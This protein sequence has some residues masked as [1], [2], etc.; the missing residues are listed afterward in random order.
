MGADVRRRG[1]ELYFRAGKEAAGRTVS[2]MLADV[3][4]L[5]GEAARKALLD[6][7][8]R[9][10]AVVCRGDEILRGGEAIRAA[11]AF[12]GA[13]AAADAEPSGRA[14]RTGTRP[15]PATP[16]VRLLYE[17]D[18]LLVADKPAG[19]IMYPG[20]PD[21]A[22]TLTQAVQRVL[23]LAGD[24]AIALPVHRLDRDTTGVCLFAKHT[25]ALRVLDGDLAARRIVRVYAAIVDGEPLRD[26]G[27]IDAP[28]GRDRHQG[29]RMRVHAGG[30]RAVTHYRVLW[31]GGLHALVEARLETGRRHQIRV[32]LAHLGHPVTGD[33]LYG[34]PA[35]GIGRQALHALSLA[36]EHPYTRES[37]VIEAP[38][39][40]DMAQLLRRLQ[41]ASRPAR[42]PGM[43]DDPRRNF[44]PPGGS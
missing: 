21:E 15:E 4:R 14:T 33:A 25:A 2:E 28:L 42:A 35:P 18:H 40:D 22:G 37:L 20:S 24:D 32:H 6:G 38:W 12:H 23:T 9:I 7:R 39:P 30:Q 27:V 11:V 34:R 36:W 8:V 41:F 17:D 5:S 26:A 43:T 29:G 19:M 1:P 13:A 3:L 10:G 31:R 16:P 44:R